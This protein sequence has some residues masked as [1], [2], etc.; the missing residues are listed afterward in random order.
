MATIPEL[1]E[2]LNTKQA[3]ASAVDL[4]TELGASRQTTLTQ[5][6][7]EKDKGNVDGDSE[8]GWVITERGKKALGAG[9]IGPSMQRR[10]L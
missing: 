2:A 1:L 5:L 4:A 8:E 9:G 7:R 10:R 6:K 3:A